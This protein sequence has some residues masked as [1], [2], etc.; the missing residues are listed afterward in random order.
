MTCPSPGSSRH[1]GS[2]ARIRASGALSWRTANLRIPIHR[3]G[4]RYIALAIA[5]NALCFAVSLWAGLVVLPLTIW[6]ILFFRDP[7]RK[8][9]EGR[10]LVISPAD[11]KLLPVIRAV[12]PPELG[13]DNTPRVRLSIFMDVFNVHV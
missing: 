4:W 6:C 10:G 9:P 12:P 5:A 3:E 1:G 2:E 8:A 11:G 7:E 13:L